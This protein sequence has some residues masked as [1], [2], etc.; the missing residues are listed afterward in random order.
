MKK[1]L[2]LILMF[3]IILPVF[4]GC[5]R[6]GSVKE[7]TENPPVL[8]V[9]LTNGYRYAPVRVLED[10]SA[11]AELEKSLGISIRLLYRDQ[12]QDAGLLNNESVS[13]V[14]LS[15]EPTLIQ[16]LADHA[17]IAQLDAAAV[18]R[19]DS[20]FGR[21]L[22]VQYG[23]VFTNGSHP[24]EPILVGSAEKLEAAGLGDIPFTAEGWTEILKKLKEVCSEPFALYGSPVDPSYAPLLALFGLAP[25]GGYEFRFGPGK[26]EYDKLSDSGRDYLKFLNG[27][28]REGYLSKDMLSMNTYS[29]GYKMLKNVSALMVIY[30]EDYLRTFLDRAESSGIRLVRI[31]LP[32]SGKLLESG[33]G[34]RF[35]GMITSDYPDR[36]LAARFL[37]S[38]DNE[39]R[40]LDISEGGPVMEP[41]TLFADGRK[42]EGAFPEELQMPE[43]NILNQSLK[44]KL[45][46]E[47]VIPYYSQIAVGEKTIG[48]FSTMVTLW[49]ESQISMLSSHFDGN[50]ILEY[51]SN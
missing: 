47:S 34:R 46:S 16:V 48:S 36:D 25:Q 39:A 23:Y 50:F 5:A 12:R 38:L 11:R 10:S 26:T 18:R 33:A 42:D 22:G 43:V 15:D 28:Y 51:Y 9:Y 13:G 32:V 4:A 40:S 3:F 14:I 7:E 45:D 21:Y 30:D 49:R 29:A 17:M 1:P 6:N 37:E 27:L 8:N 44:Y 41:Y 2:L 24:V 31:S 19:Q 20:G 35:Y